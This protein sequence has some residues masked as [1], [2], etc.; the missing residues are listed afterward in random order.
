MQQLQVEND[1]LRKTATQMNNTLAALGGGQGGSQ[2]Q[3]GNDSAVVRSA[4]NTLGLP[5]GAALPT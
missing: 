3:G 2:Q 1:N 4:Q 5:T